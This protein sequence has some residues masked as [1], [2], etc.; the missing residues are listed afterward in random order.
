MTTPRADAERWRKLPAQYQTIPYLLIHQEHLADKTLVRFSEAE[1]SYV[2]MTR[3]AVRTAGR[4]AGAGLEAGDRVAIMCSN[5]IEFLELF[6]ACA[7][8][9]AVAVPLNT[10][11][12]GPALEHVINDS[13]AR[14]LVAE[15]EFLE[16]LGEFARPPYLKLVWLLGDAP[17]GWSGDLPVAQWPGPGAAI[18]A[19]EVRPGDTAA[20][21]YTSGTTGAAKGV[22]CPHA[23]FFWGA[24]AM[25]EVLEIRSDD[26]L[27]TSLPL[28][29]INALG[30]FFKALLA[31]ASCSY[32]RRFSARRFWQEMVESDAT[33]TFLLGTMSNILMARTPSRAE[34]DHRVRIAL[35]PATSAATLAL[36]LERTGVQLVDSYGSTETGGVISAPPD[37]QRPGSMGRVLPDFEARVVD[38]NDA[39]V[40][41]GTP[42]EL[43]LRPRRPNSFAT[44]YFGVPA[45]TVETW[46]NL[47]F[48]TGDRVVQDAE[49]WLSFHDRHAELIRRRGENISSY[50]VEI[51]LQS[52]P[53]V[54]LAVAFGVPSPLGEDDVAAA[55]VLKTGAAVRA[56]DLIEHCA[57]RL[58]AFA[59]PRYVDL[60]E[61]LPVTENGKVRKA[62]LRARG[63]TSSMWDREQTRNPI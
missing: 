12:R 9:G 32:G 6:L 40:P 58:P 47:W 29:H 48:H 52:H 61:S 43:V 27:R 55:V 62:E 16:R 22:C 3:A 42:G 21:L 25:N 59:V 15:P 23:Q 4:L 31:G 35:S 54:S 1:R 5:R 17:A 41:P 56:P 60:V 2:E 11:L 38:D 18:P 50:E 24:V 7:W 36:F 46:R 63:V 49:G 8:M 39:D 19:G 53:S 26:V 44:G 34:R 30:T 13:G 20:L 57:P 51:A 37:A 45:K 14:V 10:A 33:V 28:F